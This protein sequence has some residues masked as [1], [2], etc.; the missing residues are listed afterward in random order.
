MPLMDG[1]VATSNIRT[2][3]TFARLPRVRGAP[4][5]AMTASAIQGDREKCEKA[6]MD[7]YLSKPVKKPNLERMLVRWALEGRRKQALLSVNANDSARPGQSQESSYNSQSTGSHESPQDHLSSELDR[8]EYSQRTALER[9]HESVSDKAE[10]QEQAEE[11][12]MSLRDNLLMGAGDDPRKRLGR[13]PSE[14]NIHDAE[15]ATSAQSH[16]LTTANMQALDDYAAHSAKK[17]A[18]KPSAD[19]TLSV[20]ATV[21]D[22]TPSLAPSTSMPRLAPVRSRL[23]EHD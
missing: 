4:I 11:K 7:D 13:G 1:Y 15:G 17:K 23:Q 9:S 6:G 20:A 2:S 22:E 14:Q 19:R 8:L 3:K 21:G 12:A 5:V 16:M 18:H 10:R